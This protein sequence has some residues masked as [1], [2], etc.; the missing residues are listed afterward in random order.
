MTKRPRPV[1]PCACGDHAFVPLTKGRVALIDVADMP[2]ISRWCWSASYP[3]PRVY[4]RRSRATHERH[5]TWMHRAII[6]P[7]PDGLEVDHIDGDSLNNKRSNLRLCTRQENTR[8]R[9][10]RVIAASGARGVRTF[11]GRWMARIDD[12]YLG[13]FPTKE[14]AAEAYRRAARERHGEF[15]AV[16]RVEASA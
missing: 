3:S 4:A 16:L 12:L 15:A 8:N 2:F 5:M 1:T 11:G 10:G 9:R 7:V 6:G 14:E 13:L